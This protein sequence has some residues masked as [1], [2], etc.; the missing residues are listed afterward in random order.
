[1]VL[2]APYK[3]WEGLPTVLLEAAALGV[4]VLSTNLGAM[5]DVVVNG[6]TGRL[7]EIGDIAGMLSTLVEMCSDRERLGRMSARALAEFHTRYS[8]SASLEQLLTAYA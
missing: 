7:Y 3:S 8:D 6:E 5:A 1:T 4:P 2:V